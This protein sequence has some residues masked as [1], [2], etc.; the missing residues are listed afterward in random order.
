MEFTRCGAWN[1]TSSA[2]G[3]GLASSGTF[4]VLRGAGPLGGPGMP[5]YGMLPI[6]KYL[7]AAGVTDMVRVSDARMSG[8]SYGARH[9][10]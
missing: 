8:T 5:E 7:L 6:P 2:T 10:R 9:G 4:L 3:R 1:R